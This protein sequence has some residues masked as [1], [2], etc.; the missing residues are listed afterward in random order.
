MDVAMG[1][2]RLV[3]EGTRR[4]QK[5]RLPPG[6]RAVRPG[7]FGRVEAG[8]AWTETGEAWAGQ[9][10]LPLEAEMEKKE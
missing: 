3:P 2:T 1:G 10:S 6:G 5:V 9:G 8:Q 4:F 7:V